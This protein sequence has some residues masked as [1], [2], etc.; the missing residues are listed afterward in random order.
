MLEVLAAVL[1]FA[2]GGSTLGTTAIEGQRREGIN[3]RRL[4]ASLLADLELGRLEGEMLAGNAPEIGQALTENDIFSI[5]TIVTGQ[6]GVGLGLDQALK[7][8]EADGPAAS[9]EDDE[10]GAS[11]TSLLFPRGR[12]VNPPL[13]RIELIVSWD[14]GAERYQVERTTFA[15]D[16]SGLEDAF[17]D[18]ASEDAPDNPLGGSSGDTD[19][20][21]GGS[22]SDVLEQMRRMLESAR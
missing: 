11:G 3:Q 17:P 5:E 1:I 20:P 13:R 14:E 4:E 7:E 8:N 6:D 2:G 12:N 19:T 21:E 10:N 16:T 15:L 18:S 22:E 9:S